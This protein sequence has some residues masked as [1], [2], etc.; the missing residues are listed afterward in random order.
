MRPL[1]K[2]KA[3]VL[4]VILN[5]INS[6]KTQHSYFQVLTLSKLNG[7]G[8]ATSISCFEFSNL[9]TNIAHVKLFKVLN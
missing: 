1:P 4:K 6:Y 3:S 7:S 9:H 5:Q 2:H 8:K